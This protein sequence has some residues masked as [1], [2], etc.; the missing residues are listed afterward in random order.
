MEVLA[1]MTLLSC[2]FLSAL[3]APA[4]GQEAGEETF[5]V[6]EEVLYEARTARCRVLVESDWSWR[7]LRVRLQ[8]DDDG[9]ACGLSRDET[10]DILGE[11]FTAISLRQRQAY[12]SLLLGVIEDYDWLQRHLAETAAADGDWSRRKG[13]P[14]AGGSANAY[15][16]AVLGRPAILQSMNRAVEDSGHV[17]EGFGCE[18]IRISDDGLPVDG[19]CG[20]DLAE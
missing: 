14:K 19:F 7:T 11:T 1:R 17:F 12:R 3:A 2:A 8:R 13:R 5:E 10:L 6:L 18:K 20:M 9:Q 4:P 15:V 16:E